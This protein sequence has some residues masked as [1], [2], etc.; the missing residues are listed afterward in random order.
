[1]FQTYH[2]LFPPLSGRASVYSP[3]HHVG[4]QGRPRQSS[5]PP[6]SA[7]TCFVPFLGVAPGWYFTG[8]VVVLLYLLGLAM[9]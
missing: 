5:S 4:L 3:H 8:D 2:D 1:M 6:P 7:A 9:S